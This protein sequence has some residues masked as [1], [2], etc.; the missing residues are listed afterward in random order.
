MKCNHEWLTPEHNKTVCKRC[1]R[2]GW[3]SL[4]VQAETTPKC[5]DAD[6]CWEKANELAD[7]KDL[8][9]HRSPPNIFF[10]WLRANVTG[11]QKDDETSTVQTQ[12]DVT[13]TTE[14]VTP[15]CMICGPN[16]VGKCPHGN[17]QL[18]FENPLIDATYVNG[19]KKRIA[20]LEEQLA[21][22]DRNPFSR[23]LIATKIEEISKLTAE[24]ERLKM[25]LS[26]RAESNE[27]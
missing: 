8:N 24:N 14:S 16:Y 18:V 13:L 12:D 6:A 20:E 17:R 23:E 9:A 15:E 27:R 3:I 10:E 19:L 22:Y 11:F 5:P 2:D 1:G 21:S 25:Y 26:L 4:D 7:Y